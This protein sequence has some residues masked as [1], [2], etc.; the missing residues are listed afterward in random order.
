MLIVSCAFVSAV[1]DNSTSVGSEQTSGSSGVDQNDDSQ[2]EE[3]TT[4]DEEIDLDV[5]VDN[6]DENSD[7]NV[8]NES[9]NHHFTVDLQKHATGNPILILIALFSFF[10]P[11][12]R[13]E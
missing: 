11:F 12:L 4:G 3:D 8:L 5:T 9:D 6:D 1:D 7:E 2:S 10:L 13:H